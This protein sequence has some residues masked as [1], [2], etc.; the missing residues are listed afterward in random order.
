MIG[1]GVSSLS[2]FDGIHFQNAHLYEDYVN[3]LAAGR[4]PLWR[5]LVLTERSRS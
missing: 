3:Q 2:H 4:L 1:L 5:P